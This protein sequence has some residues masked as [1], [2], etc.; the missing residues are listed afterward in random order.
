[1]TITP[2]DRQ[3]LAQIGVRIVDAE[4]RLEMPKESKIDFS[5]GGSLR[6]GGFNEEVEIKYV[7]NG[8]LLIIYR[9]EGSENFASATLDIYTGELF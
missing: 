5:Y 6:S 4:E 3:A 2:E 7:G 9:E 8:R 1:L